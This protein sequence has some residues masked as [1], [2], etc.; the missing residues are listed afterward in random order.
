MKKF[1]IECRKDGSEVWRNMRTIE[2]GDIEMAWGIYSDF[3]YY[4]DNLKVLEDAEKLENL[5]K[6][7]SNF[8]EF[9]RIVPIKLIDDGWGEMVEV[10]DFD[11]AA[12]VYLDN[13]SNF[14][15]D[16]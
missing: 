12:D 14:K 16:Y 3:G 13:Y 15:I 8:K 11:N 2:C 5:K 1:I 10:R 6:D 4:S 7:I 9:Y